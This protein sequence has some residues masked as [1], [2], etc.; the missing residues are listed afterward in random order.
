MSHPAA[1]AYVLHIY[2]NHEW[3]P[4]GSFLL[5]LYQCWGK[6]MDWSPKIVQAAES[7]SLDKVQVCDFR[8]GAGCVP[9]LVMPLEMP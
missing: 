4:A 5:L 9:A 8:G 2:L 6:T 3:Q 7:C 1:L